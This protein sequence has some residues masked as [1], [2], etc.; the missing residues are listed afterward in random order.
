MPNETK[1]T[2]IPGQGNTPNGCRVVRGDQII[3]RLSRNADCSIDEKWRNAHLI[4]AAP[5]LYEAL[6]HC[7]NTLTSN[8]DLQEITA[9]LTQSW[10]ALAKARG[11]HAE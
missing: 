9:T 10:R 7:Y 2:L 3:C 6:T 5:E 4:A 1:W 8:S 11:E